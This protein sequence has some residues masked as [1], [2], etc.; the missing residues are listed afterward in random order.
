M[1][2]GL[3]EFE[4]ADLSSLSQLPTPDQ[5]N[6]SYTEKLHIK[7]EG[8]KILHGKYKS[9]RRTTSLLDLFFPSS[10][11][12]SNNGRFFA[13]VVLFVFVLY[14]S[15]FVK[16]FRTFF[17]FYFRNFYF[18]LLFLLTVMTV[19]N[20]LFIILLFAR[21]ATCIS[22][23]EP[24]GSKEASLSTSSDHNKEE[25]ISRNAFRGSKCNDYW[26]FL[27]SFPLFLRSFT[28][29]CNN[30]ASIT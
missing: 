28:F 20:M 4:E 12:R 19:R 30:W 27:W 5:L 2:L 9:S 21:H 26:Y 22:A 7:K 23:M 24:T 3:I 1:D 15:N 8:K 18:Y 13:F 16:N 10:L 29:S 6:S 25:P 11:G 17:F 14:V